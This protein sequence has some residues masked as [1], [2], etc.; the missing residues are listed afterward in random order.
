MRIASVIFISFC[1]QMARA[2]PVPGCPAPTDAEFRMTTLA[3]RQGANLN[4]P[5]KMDFDMGGSGDVDIWFI[6]KA[7]LV[8]KLN[9]ATRTV[10]NVGKLNVHVQDEYGLMGIVLDPKF[11]ANRWLY[12]FYMPNAQPYEL[13]LSRF[14]VNAGQLDLAS[15]KVLIKNAATVGWHGGGGLA[16]DP[17]GN[18]WV[19]IGDTRA[20]QVAAPNTNDLRGKILRIHPR[21][22]GTYSI[23]EGNLFPKAADGGPVGALGLDHRKH[24]ADRHLVPDFARELDHLACDRRLHLDGGLVGHHV[25]DL[26]IFPDLVADFDV[27][28][29][30]LRLG[31]AFADVGQLEFVSGH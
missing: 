16:F 18:L 6:E 26:L 10:S 4:E 5:L 23:P 31:N 9:G 29:D 11:K 8:R 17:D 21:D 15:E 19:A 25:G 24:G 2:V 27:P 30:D 7:G 22:D 14:T 3:T 12:L 1:F 20:G 28:G 13:R